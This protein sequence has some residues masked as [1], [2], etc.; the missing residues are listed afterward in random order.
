MT[1]RFDSR[2][3]EGLSLIHIYMANPLIWCALGYGVLTFKIKRLA[4]VLFPLV[5]PFYLYK[6]NKS[7]SCYVH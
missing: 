7:T 6:G 3:V 4:E 5:R 1:S 2:S